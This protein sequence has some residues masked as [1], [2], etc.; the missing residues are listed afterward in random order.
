[1]SKFN[2]KSIEVKKGSKGFG[3]AFRDKVEGEDDR[4]GVFVDYVTPDGSADLSGIKKSDNILKINGQQPKDLN[5]AKNLVR[6]SADLLKLDIFHCPLAKME[7]ANG[8]KMM[9]NS[10]LFLRLQFFCLVSFLQKLSIAT[11]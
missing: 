1:M 11:S 9:V 3:L 7:S 6:L 8:V 10:P 2:S 4:N 5:D